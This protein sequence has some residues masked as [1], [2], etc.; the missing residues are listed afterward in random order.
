M[1]GCS[2]RCTML[3]CVDW[4]NWIVVVSVVAVD[5]CWRAA[6]GSKNK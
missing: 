1:E 2:S 5:I 4:A 3:S 6:V